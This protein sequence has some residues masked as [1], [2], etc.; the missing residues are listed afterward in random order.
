M[1]IYI[2]INYY[3]IQISKGLIV[4]TISYFLLNKNMNV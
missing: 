1:N 2:K 3:K 4:K